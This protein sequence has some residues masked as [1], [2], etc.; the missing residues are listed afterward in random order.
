MSIEW[1]NIIFGHLEK[2][3]ITNTS[4]EKWEADLL[5]INWKHILKI[6]RERCTEIHGTTPEQI[7]KVQKSTYTGRN[8]TDTVRKY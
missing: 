2:E 5:Y 1:G 3:K 6:W 4:A 8:T 7:K